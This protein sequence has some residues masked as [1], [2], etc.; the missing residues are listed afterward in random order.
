MSYA[1]R[2]LPS[3]QKDI[4]KIPE[5]MLRRIQEALKPLAENPHPPGAKK[6]QGYDG[7]FRLRIGDYRVVYSVTHEIRIV[8]IIRIGHRREVYRAL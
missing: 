6:I 1:I 4:R 2:F 8:T 3:V 7:C 5:G